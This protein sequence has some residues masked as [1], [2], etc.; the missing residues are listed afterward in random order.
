V[1]RCRVGGNNEGKFCDI[2]LLV[3]GALSISS[4]DVGIVVFGKCVHRV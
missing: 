1:R 3:V 4:I 2:V